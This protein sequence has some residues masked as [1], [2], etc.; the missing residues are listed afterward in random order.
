M[1]S[2]LASTAYMGALCSANPVINIDECPKE[3][4]R[5]SL[6]AQYSQIQE[7]SQNP[8]N[9]NSQNHRL[10][11]AI[12]AGYL[13]LEGGIANK[14][15]RLHFVLSGKIGAGK[16]S[17]SKSSA[18][19][20]SGGEQNI[21]FSGI[22]F[23]KENLAIFGEIKPKAGIN[24]AHKKY[25]LYL[26]LAYTF[27]AYTS[28]KKNNGGYSYLFH[29][30]GTELEGVIPIGQ[31]FALE[32]STGYDWLFSGGY[33]FEGAKDSSLSA[34]SLNGHS[35]ALNASVGF[36]YGLNNGRLYF[37]KLIGKYQNLGASKPTSEG[38]SMP[39]LKNLIGSLEVG[40]G[41]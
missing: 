7:K 11:N 10:N 16:I 32:Y 3:Y 17:A 1:M 38:L 20:S 4:T 22:S 35:Y 14:T 18:S 39:H 9:P 6:G 41:F 8:N 29:Y 27:E 15:N 36:S 37:C 31:R 5:I 28:R 25:S 13:N 2:F 30:L 33:G 24:L 23:A 26:N 40:I 34:F 12:Y 21:Q 19:K